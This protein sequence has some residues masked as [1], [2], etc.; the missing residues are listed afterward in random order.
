MNS[1]NAHFCEPIYF[2]FITDFGVSMQK[3]GMAAAPKEAVLQVRKNCY[4]VNKTVDSW[5]GS[6]LN[7]NLHLRFESTHEIDD[8]ASSS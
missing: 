1:R 8:P 5:T 7:I 4:F 6:P 3:I 2:P